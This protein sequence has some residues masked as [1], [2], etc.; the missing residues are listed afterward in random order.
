LGLVHVIVS[1]VRNLIES[2]IMEL[3]KT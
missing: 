2:E 3:N 1:R